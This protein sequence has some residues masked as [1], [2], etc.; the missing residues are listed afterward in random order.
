MRV[1]KSPRA[2]EEEKVD[3]YEMQKAYKTPDETEMY[4]HFNLYVAKIKIKQRKG[5]CNGD[6][7]NV[8][9]GLECVKEFDE[10][11]DQIVDEPY[12]MIHSPF[13]HKDN[14]IESLDNND[15]KDRDIED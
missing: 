3:K 13:S 1:P 5:Q 14:A 10:A 6:D 8:T 2:K 15:S 4:R 12:T 7:N 11:V 9:L